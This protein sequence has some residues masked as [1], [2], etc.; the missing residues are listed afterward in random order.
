MAAAATLAGTLLGII[1]CSAVAVHWAMTGA[2]TL[3]GY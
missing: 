3:L 2:F 1:V